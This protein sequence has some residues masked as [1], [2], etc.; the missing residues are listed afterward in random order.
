MSSGFQIGR[1]FGRSVACPIIVTVRVPASRAR[2][3]TYVGLA[4]FAGGLLALTAWQ[5]ALPPSLPST[6]GTNP[7]GVADFRDAL[8]LPAYTAGIASFRWTFRLLLLATW[9]GYV[10]A[11]L[12]TAAGGRL[13]RAVVWASAG[14]AALALAVFW[15]SS[16]SVDVYGYVAYGRLHVIDGIN[17]YVGSVRLPPGFNDPTAHFLTI[18]TPYG[19]LWSWVSAACVAVMSGASTW[20]QVVALKL[21]AAGAT[22]SIAWTGR[23]LAEHLEAGRGELTLV[24]LAFNPLLLIEGAGSGHNDLV[25][26]ALIL[27]ALLAV[28]RERLRAGALIIG[29]AAAIKFLPLLLLPWMAAR[30]WRS[31]PG[32]VGR[33]AAD[34]AL[35]L[36]AGVAPTV[37][38][39]APLWQGTATLH[40]LHERWARGMAA[41]GSVTDAR[42]QNIIL[43]AIYLAVSGWVVARPDVFRMTTGWIVAASAVLALATGL[44][45]PWYLSWMLA[46][47]LCRWSKPYVATT[48][49][50]AG[51]ALLFTFRY[52]VVPGG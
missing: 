15:P 5:Y 19:P 17:P 16:L 43:I 12:G 27:A 18:K 45:F 38:A 52:L 34:A 7:F 47:S 4:L 39:F 42:V 28:A 14:I 41:S 36:V 44:W 13:P 50:V 35:V 2:L 20:A 1:C 11:L 51:L 21:L 6:W 48:C 33:R 24:A 26:M 3:A 37:I 23:A 8:G 40:G 29:V 46:A 31:R 30:A 49:A 22:L 25:M 10:L 32:G 9:A